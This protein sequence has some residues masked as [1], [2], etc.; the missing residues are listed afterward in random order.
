M[1]NPPTVILTDI[2]FLQEQWIETFNRFRLEQL[3]NNANMSLNIGSRNERNARIQYERIARITYEKIARIHFERIARIARMQYKSLNYFSSYIGLLYEIY[4][5]QDY[6]HM[7][8]QSLINNTKK[9]KVIMNNNINLYCSICFEQYKTNDSLKIF[10]CCHHFC[11]NCIDKWIVN[12]ITCPCCRQTILDN[13]V[14]DS[15]LTKIYFENNKFGEYLLKI[16]NNKRKIFQKNIIDKNYLIKIDQI[17]ILTNKKNKINRDLINF[18]CYCIYKI[19]ILHNYNKI[20][21]NL[22]NSNQNKFILLLN[23][24]NNYKNLKKLY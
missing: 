6:R 16:I 13:D 15:G 5:R 19:K 9:H 1:S 14:I 8:R 12:K 7:L 11:S 22:I 3:F 20:E 24:I 10:D 18:M 23:L 2:E 17:E 4:T 21:K